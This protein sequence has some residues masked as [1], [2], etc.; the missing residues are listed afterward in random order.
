MSPP[1]DSDLA[2]SFIEGARLDNSADFVVGY[3]GAYKFEEFDII[4]Q[5]VLNW[6]SGGPDIRFEFIGGAS[7][8]L[9]QLESVQWFPGF[10]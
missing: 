10:C 7:A 5:A 3:A 1:F 6:L 8:R 4:E 2:E 9:R